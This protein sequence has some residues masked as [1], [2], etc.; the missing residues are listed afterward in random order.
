MSLSLPALKE[1]N[2]PKSKEELITEISYL[3]D[4]VEK[5]PDRLYRS[6]ADF[7]DAVQKVCD[8]V[9]KRKFEYDEDITHIYE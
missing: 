8:E 1:E 5:L 9:P 7:E 6:A 3:R 4:I 2:F